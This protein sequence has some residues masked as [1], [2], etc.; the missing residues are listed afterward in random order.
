MNTQTRSH[1]IT[2]Y[3]WNEMSAI[4]INTIIGVEN[5]MVI[6]Q[7]HTVCTSLKGNV[8]QSLLQT[9]AYIAWT[10]VTSHQFTIYVIESCNIIITCA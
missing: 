8:Q 9:V 10:P 3:Y 1:C 6:A 5:C 2:G 4:C 7:Q